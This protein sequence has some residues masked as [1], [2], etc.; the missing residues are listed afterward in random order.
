ME[1]R[2]GGGLLSGRLMSGAGV[3]V[4]PFHLFLLLEEREQRERCIH[5][6]VH[7]KIWVCCVHIDDKDVFENK[8]IHERERERERERASSPLIN[9]FS[10]SIQIYK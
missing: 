6:H 5:T 4:D 2:G 3:V 10:L 9:N 1:G 8:K 7:A